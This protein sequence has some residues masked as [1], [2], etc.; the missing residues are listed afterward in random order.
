M[1]LLF[2]ILFSTPLSYL[3]ICSYLS[4]DMGFHEY[5]SHKPV[6]FKPTCIVKHCVLLLLAV[7]VYLICTTLFHLQ[8][9][10]IVAKNKIKSWS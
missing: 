6:F 7:Y 3:P 9:E 4:T 1:N 8:S 2:L 5:L 10:D